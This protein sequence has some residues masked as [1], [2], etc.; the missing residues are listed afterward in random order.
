MKVTYE[1][2]ATTLEIQPEETLL[3]AAQRGGVDIVATC[4]G[5]GLCH[6]CRIR[7]LEG[8]FTPPT[9]RE[10][11][12]LGDHGLAQGF[13]LA[14]QTKALSDGLVRIAPPIS[15]QAFRILSHTDRQDYEIAP[16]IVK[17]HVTLPSTSEEKQSSDFENLQD[18]LTELSGDH[19]LQQIDLHALQ[20]LPAAIFR[21][22][23]Q[24]TTVVWDHHLLAIEAGDTTDHIYGIAFD[25]G[26]TTVVGYLLDLR[27]GREMAVASALNAQARY[28]GDVMSRITL[29]Q[30]QETGLQILHDS[31]IGTINR[32]ITQVC[33]QAGIARDRIYELSIVGNTCMHHLFL[34]IPPVHLGLAPYLAAIREQYV[35]TAGELGLQIAPQGRVVMLPLIAAFVG[36][37]TVGV[38]L[39]TGMHKSSAVK[40]AVDIGTNGEIVLGAQDRLVAC[41]TA[42]GTAFEG[43]Q[44]TYGMHGAAGAIDRVTIDDDVH[45]H[46]IGDEPARGICGSG[47]VDAIAQLLDAGI[48]TPTGRFRK[49]HE[50]DEAG[51]PPQLRQ[52]LIKVGGKRQFVLVEAEHA[53]SGEP[54]VLT[55][56]DVRELQLAKGAIAA[57]IAI[58]MEQLQIQADDVSEILLAGAF[59]NYL[60]PRSAVRIGL[61]PGL[62]ASRIRSVGNA[63]GLGS[64]LALLSGQAKQEAAQIANTTEHIALTNDPAFQL[65]FAD[66][67][68]FP[69]AMP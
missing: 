54:L 13:R 42:A 33:E 27:T 68:G 3:Q 49:P 35:T 37:D 11:Q 36:A 47:L 48:L 38:I 65:A 25:V 59:G 14:C 2:D 6:S 43:A 61:I 17:R 60:D 19:C 53:D 46:V 57:G 10:E 24:I 30:E 4:G 23:R 58:L 34:N 51:V 63:A 40:L 26:T 31:I 18:M 66:A 8:R 39:A 56:H 52:R 67:M 41:S 50:L 62:P 55:Q 21:A 16:D 29:A 44:I 32:I 9:D 15:E 45:C 1:P 28:G 22:S 7:I 64:Q 5:R 69:A 12:V 20:T